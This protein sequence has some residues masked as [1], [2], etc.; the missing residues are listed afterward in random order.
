M[1]C[2]V[3]HHKFRDRNIE[4]ERNQSVFRKNMQDFFLKNQIPKQG[5]FENDLSQSGG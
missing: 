2:G 1:C 4:G 3:F 5:H